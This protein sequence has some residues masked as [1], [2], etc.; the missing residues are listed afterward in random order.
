MTHLSLFGSTLDVR[1]STFDVRVF[2]L[3]FNVGCS[4]FDVRRSRFLSLVQRWMFDVRRS[5]FAFSFWFNVGCSTF[6]VRRS[7]FAF[8][9]HGQ[10]GRAPLAGWLLSPDISCQTRQQCRGSI[11]LPSSD[12]PMIYYLRTIG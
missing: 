11:H 4:T 6:D 8:S 2:S 5:M 3:W 10:A 1:R 9:S 12:K 7:M